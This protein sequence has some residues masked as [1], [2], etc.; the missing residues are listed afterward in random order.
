MLLLQCVDFM[1]GMGWISHM[2]AMQKNHLAATTLFLVAVWSS[3]GAKFSR[4]LDK[5]PDLRTNYCL[6]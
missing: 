3:W 6:P 5:S 4:G 2:V 1:M